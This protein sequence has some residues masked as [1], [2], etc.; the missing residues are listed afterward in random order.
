MATYANAEPA[1]LRQDFA[2]SLQAAWTVEEIREQLEQA[3]LPL[4]TA[5]ISDRHVLVSG[6]LS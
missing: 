6:R 2:N 4:Q 3:G 5:A 1:I